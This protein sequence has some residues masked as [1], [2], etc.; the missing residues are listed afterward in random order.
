MELTKILFFLIGTF[1]GVEQSRVLSEKTTITINPEEKTIVVVQEN[2]VSLIQ[3]ANDSLKVYA[4]LKVIVQPKHQWS[5]EFKDYTKKEKCFFISDDGKTLN[6][7]INLTYKTSTDLKAFGI[8][9]NK[10]GALSMIDTPKLNIN[11]TDGKLGERYWNFD[12]DKPFTFTIEPLTD[13]PEEYKAYKK[14][15]L[16]VWKTIKH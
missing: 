4:E 14:S 12:A 11:S 13:I 1:F 5:T 15:L 10:D 3:N 8:D 2:I 6:S 16:P 9:I 7:K